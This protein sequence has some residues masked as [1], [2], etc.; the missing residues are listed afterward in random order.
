MHE[1]LGVFEFLS[2]STTD[3]GV[4]CTGGSENIIYQGFS[5]ILIRIYLL[6]ADKQNWHNSLCLNLDLVVVSRSESSVYEHNCKTW[7]LLT[8]CWLSGERPLPIVILV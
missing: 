5:T 7:C 3:Y 2:E 4:S 1:S 6:L 8:L